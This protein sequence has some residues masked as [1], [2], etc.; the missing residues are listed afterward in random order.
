MYRTNNIFTYIYNYVIVLVLFKQ[1]GGKKA[2][3]EDTPEMK[4]LS[5]IC[6][7]THFTY[8]VLNCLLFCFNILNNL[9]LVFCI[10]KI[11]CILFYIMFTMLN[12]ILS[13]LYFNFTDYHML[14][15]NNRTVLR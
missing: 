8:F 13:L 7:H 1:G 12:N 11:L 4:A 2:I 10:R 14:Y 6:F 5:N 3:R 9:I 15:R